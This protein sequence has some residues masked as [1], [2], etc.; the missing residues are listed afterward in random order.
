[1]WQWIRR[2]RYLFEIVILP[3]L[4]IYP[5]VGLLDYII[6]LLF[7]FG[8]TF[9][10]FCITTLQ[11]YIPKQYTSIPFS[12]HPHQHLLPLLFL[13]IVILTD[14]RLYLTVALICIFL[15]ISDVEHLFLYL[16]PFEYLLWW[17]VAQ[18]AIWL[19][20][21]EICQFRYFAHF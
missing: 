7:I 2:Y 3:P 16:W 17:L 8:G 13:V 20:S 12:P 5:K 10:L 19:S 15:I 21:L 1:M 11:I 18:L 6:I 14:V 4:G 9:I